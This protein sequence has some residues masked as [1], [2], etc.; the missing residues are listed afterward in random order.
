MCLGRWSRQIYGMA[1]VRYCPQRRSFKFMAN[2][3]EFMAVF[4]Y[5]RQ[6]PGIWDDEK[7]WQKATA[8]R[9]SARSSVVAGVGDRAAFGAPETRRP[10]G[11]G[12]ATCVIGNGKILMA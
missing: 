10:A 11:T 2:F 5:C 7:P 4:R 1:V 3:R 6:K 12:G 8:K 9:Q